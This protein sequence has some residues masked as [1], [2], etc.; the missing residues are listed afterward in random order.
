MSKIRGSYEFTP[1]HYRKHVKLKPGRRCNICHKWIKDYPADYDP[2]YVRFCLD[3]RVTRV[4]SDRAP[5][6]GKLYL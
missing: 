4:Q 2:R 6:T 1:I 5:A 3:C